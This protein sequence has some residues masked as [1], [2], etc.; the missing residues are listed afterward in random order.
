MTLS[1]RLFATALL[2]LACTGWPARAA[3][4]ADREPHAL[5]ESVTEQTLA[6]IERHRDSFTQNPQPFFDDINRILGDNADIP[7]IAKGVMGK[8]YRLATEEQRAAFAEVFQR[9]L[10]ETYAKALMGFDNEKIVVL[11]PQG[12]SREPNTATVNMEV[13]SDSGNVYPVSYSLFLDDQGHWK[14]KNVIVNGINLGLTF[15][16]QFA[17]ALRQSRDI[18]RVIQEWQP[19]V[20]EPAT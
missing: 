20:D 11:P 15:R 12:P 9:S 6:A 13:Y 8:Y 10:I 18:D 1:T 19:V 16:N 2:A 14:L 4:T 5:I 7:G 3:L 17:T